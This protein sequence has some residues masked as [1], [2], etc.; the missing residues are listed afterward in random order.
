MPRLRRKKNKAPD[1]AVAVIGLLLLVVFCFPA[2][3]EFSSR[4]TRRFFA[5]FLLL[6]ENARI[7]VSDKSLMLRT[8][9]ELASEMERLMQENMLLSAQV[10]QAAPL[11]LENEELRRMLKVNPRPGFRYIYAR[12]LMRDPLDWAGS[13]T[14]DQGSN[15]GVNVG[16]IVLTPYYHNERIIPVVLGRI[17]SVTD[18]TANIATVI[19]PDC[20]LSIVISGLGVSACLSGGGNDESGFYATAEYLPKGLKYRQ[21]SPAYTAGFDAKIPPNLY[22]GKLDIPQRGELELGQRLYLSAKLRPAADLQAVYF[23]MIMVREQK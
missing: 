14:I 18:D 10:A 3:R 1:Y 17:I 13:L 4:I 20:R 16:A 15:D 11:K 5:P 9:S 2:A 22:I 19:N 12:P 21:A 7:A 6:P 23:V 8:K